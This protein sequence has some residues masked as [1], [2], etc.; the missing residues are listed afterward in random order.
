MD[1]IYWM[2]PEFTSHPYLILKG[3]RR[4]NNI[5]F[6][7]FSPLYIAILYSSVPSRQ[8]FKQTY[9]KSQKFII[10][11]AIL[12]DWKGRTYS[13]Q[14][15]NFLSFKHLIITVRLKCPF[16]KNELRNSGNLFTWT[17]LIWAMEMFNRK[18]FR[19]FATHS[20][21]TDTLERQISNL[22]DNTTIYLSVE[23]FHCFF[24]WVSP[25]SF[26][27]EFFRQCFWLG[28]F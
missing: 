2:Y 18:E 9:F 11:Y 10:K 21:K 15:I 7:V 28:Y 25:V 26:F 8:F 17:R 3:K 6:G 16:R 23:F 5:T 14:Y 22:L 19:N 13:W 12:I 1:F 4:Q 20:Y 27:N 24:Q